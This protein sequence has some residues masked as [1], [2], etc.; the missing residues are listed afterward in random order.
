MHSNM[1]EFVVIRMTMS[2]ASFLGWLWN[3]L[4]AHCSTLASKGNDI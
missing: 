2:A 4:S 1:I 3:L